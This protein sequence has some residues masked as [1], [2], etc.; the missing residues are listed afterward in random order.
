LAGLDEAEASTM[1]RQFAFEVCSGRNANATHKFS[2][3]TEFGDDSFSFTVDEISMLNTLLEGRY[4]VEANRHVPAATI[5]GLANTSPLH[6][7]RELALAVEPMPCRLSTEDLVELL[8]MPT[9][10]GE[11]RRTVLVQLGNRYGRTFGNHW[12]FVRYAEEQQLGLDFT[13]PPKRPERA[14]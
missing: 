4:R 3:S 12:E 13:S 6:A 1:A 5:V 9:C 14:Y 11:A 8:K 10:Y 7:L 2:T